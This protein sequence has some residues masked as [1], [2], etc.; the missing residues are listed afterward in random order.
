MAKSKQELRWGFSTGAC[1]A[2]IATAS[3][4]CHGKNPCQV[5]ALSELVV[6]FLDGQSRT[7]GLLPSDTVQGFTSIRKDGGD[8]PDCT[9][10]AILYGSL[11]ECID[12]DIGCAEAQ[13]YVIAF[14]CHG[15]ILRQ[16]VIDNNED[17]EKTTLII[18]GIEGIGLCTRIGL[19][20]SQGKWAINTGPRAMIALNLAKAGLHSGTWI[21]RLGVQNGEKLSRHTLNK[22]LGIKGGISILGTT[23]HVRPYSHDAYI[24][25]VRICVQSNALSNGRHMVFCTGGRTMRGAQAL[26]TDL[27]ETAFV[28]IGDFIAESLAAAKKHSMNEVTVAC[29]AGK[30]CKYAAGFEYT[31]AHTV[32]QDMELLRKVIADQLDAQIA[33]PDDFYTAPTVREA[34]LHLPENTRLLVMKGLAEHA[35]TIFAQRCDAKI[36]RIA[37]FDFDGTFLFSST[38][39]NEE[40]MK[41]I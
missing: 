29:M 37:V 26:F 19:D 33:L 14:D 25:T 17:I 4:L 23:G 15:H 10:K 12:G 41:R 7:L 34:L 38:R 30:L 11:E 6:H 35:L 28:C 8:D 2:A 5:P 20:C 39:Q 3:W 36:I 16:E 1:A 32:A 9:H 13:D 22:Q 31:H 21:L 18:H 27:P 40:D 24:A